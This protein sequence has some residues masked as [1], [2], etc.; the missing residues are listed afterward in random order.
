MKNTR[1]YLI[2]LTIIPIT[3]LL[4][5]YKNQVNRVELP[6]T[7]K[8][9]QN[10]LFKTK[11]FPLE[12][13]TPYW[14]RVNQNSFFVY[15]LAKN[16]IFKLN[17]NGRI[18]DKI[19]NS[20]TIKFKLIINYIA[21]SSLLHI[22]DERERKF[23]AI[24]AKDNTVLKKD[25]LEPFLRALPFSDH[26]AIF[27][28]IDKNTSDIKFVKT[29][30]NG[31]INILTFPLTKASDGGFANDGFFSTYSKPN[32]LAYVY[33]HLGKFMLFDSSGKD[34]RTYKTIDNYQKV[35]VVA[36]VS[37]RHTLSKKTLTT[38]RVS[39][40]NSKY[41]F[42]VSNMKSKQDNID[43]VTGDVIDVYDSETGTYSHS[44]KVGNSKKDEIVDIS[45]NEDY[46]FLLTKSDIL[47]YKIK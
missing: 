22:I 30:T 3:F 43:L 36:N 2:C 21:D 31:S 13:I 11:S 16:E 15:D 9:A 1:F 45:L 38:N 20:D 32:R 8:Y 29:N 37:G 4:F 7:R 26:T 6:F 12:N 5:L 42:L 25:T 10:S 41:L 40:I 24:S 39:A 35:P 18:E 44:F 14:L 23:Y 19:G 46:L 34:C 27:G 33:Y 47:Q 28:I 17:N